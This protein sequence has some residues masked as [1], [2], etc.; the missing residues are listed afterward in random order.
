MSV[1]SSSPPPQPKI[2]S[3][4][5]DKSIVISVICVFSRNNK[6]TALKYKDH[7]AKIFNWA[8]DQ[9]WIDEDDTD[10]RTIIYQWLKDCLEDYLCRVG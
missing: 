5:P 10:K 2:A 8:K 3:Y 9:E 4:A 6:K 7:I 1:Q